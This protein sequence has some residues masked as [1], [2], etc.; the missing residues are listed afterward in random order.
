MFADKI[1]S[2]VQHSAVYNTDQADKN[3][4]DSSIAQGN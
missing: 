2:I 1:K 3:K 4:I